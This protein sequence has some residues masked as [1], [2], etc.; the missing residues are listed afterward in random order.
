[1]CIRNFELFK[2]RNPS[3]C[4]PTSV[5]IKFLYGSFRPTVIVNCHKIGP[6][7]VLKTLFDRSSC[8]QD[9]GGVVC[10]TWK[11]CR[12]VCGESTQSYGQR[13][14][15]MQGAA[16]V[17]SADV[18]YCI[19]A[20]SQYYCIISHSRKVYKPWNSRYRTVIKICLPYTSVVIWNNTTRDL[21]DRNF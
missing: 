5:G 7:S 14:V 20:L 10:G 1:M 9:R 12:G 11:I 16:A 4:W 21:L 15:E 2:R 17:A 3:S 6:I 19:F 13:P 8:R 18:R